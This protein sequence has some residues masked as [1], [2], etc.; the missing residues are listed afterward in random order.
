MAFTLRSACMAD[1]NFRNMTLDGVS[2]ERTNIS[3]AFALS[4]HLIKMKLAVAFR[5]RGAMTFS[6]ASSQMPKKHETFRTFDHSHKTNNGN[7]SHDG[8]RPDV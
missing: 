1:C 3:S 6:F 2:E 5:K 4:Q 8:V 7:L